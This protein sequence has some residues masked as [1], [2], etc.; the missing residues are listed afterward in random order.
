MNG[1]FLPS[2]RVALPKAVPLGQEIAD[3]VSRRQL[4]PLETQSQAHA[5]A[6]STAHPADNAADSIGGNG[7]ERIPAGSSVYRRRPRAHAAHIESSR[8]GASAVAAW[9]EVQGCDTVLHTDSNGA[10]VTRRAIFESIR[11]LVSTQQYSQLLSYFAGHGIVLAA[12]TETWL[13][14][15]AAND[16]AEA[17]NMLLSAEYARSAGIKHVV[18]ISDAC[19]TSARRPFNLT[20]LSV[21]R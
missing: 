4:S 20:G 15:D 19:R 16:P 13:L 5:P 10:A 18:L 2:S 3:H 9:A 21:S 17:I 11:D 14:S 1:Y 8:S 7:L 6:R 12:G